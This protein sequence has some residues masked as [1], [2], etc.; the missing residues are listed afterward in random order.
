MRGG[1][2]PHPGDQ[3]SQ[4]PVALWG[5]WAD[6]NDLGQGFL[7]VLTPGLGS[8]TEGPARMIHL[9]INGRHRPSRYEA[10]VNVP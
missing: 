5:Q 1:E 7:A 10:E 2:F 4:G 6:R 3:G 8:G 9:P